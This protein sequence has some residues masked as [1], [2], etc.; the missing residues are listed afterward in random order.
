M[1]IAVGWNDACQHGPKPSRTECQHLPYVWLPKYE[2]YSKIAKTM[3]KT[4]PEVSRLR[5]SNFHTCTTD[6]LKYLRYTFSFPSDN[7]RL[8]C[9]RSLWRAKW[10]GYLCFACFTVIERFSICKTVFKTPP[11][12]SKLRH[13]NF[14]TCTSD[15]LKYLRYTFSFPSDNCSLSYWSST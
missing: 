15:Y 14:H 4:P 3:F 11:E 2:N 8:S 6:Y 5:H 12:V 7:C 9:C 13:S 10:L 1:N